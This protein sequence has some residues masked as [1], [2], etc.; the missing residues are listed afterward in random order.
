MPNFEVDYSYK[1]NEYG[2]NV[3]NADDNAD[4]MNKTVDYVLG[5]DPTYF[6]VEIEEVREVAA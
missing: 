5:L 3:V 2:T 4:A 6:G 1:V